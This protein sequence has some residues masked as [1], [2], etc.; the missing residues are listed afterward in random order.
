[1][2]SIWWTTNKWENE[3]HVGPLHIK[4]PTNKQTNHMS[5]YIKMVLYR[6]KELNVG[7][8]TIL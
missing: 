4:K 5:I 2:T 6:K 7:S 1:M 3:D 8:Y